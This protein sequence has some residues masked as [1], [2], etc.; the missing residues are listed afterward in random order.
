MIY[1]LDLCPMSLH[2]IG[3]Y[4]FDVLQIYLSSRFRSSFSSS[5]SSKS[6]CGRKSF[7]S[8]SGE[9]I[10]EDYFS[11]SEN[12]NNCLS[13]KENILYSD[14]SLKQLDH[15]RLFTKMPPT[16][17]KLPGRQTNNSLSSITGQ[18]VIDAPPTSQP[19]PS[20]SRKKKTKAEV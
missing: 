7:V 1:C 2:E 11:L 20:T 8:L 17:V 15:P 14:L 18:I 19:G 3:I 9:S 12:Q 10:A 4:A 16:S 6:S 13:N 5:A